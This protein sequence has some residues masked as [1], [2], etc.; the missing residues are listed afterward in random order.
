MTLPDIPDGAVDAAV[1]AW[2]YDHRIHPDQ[3]RAEARE[4]LSAVWPHLY[5]AALRHAADEIDKPITRL[6]RHPGRAARWVSPGE[7]LR[8]LADEAVPE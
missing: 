6:D 1:L 5:A 8:R 7:A 4:G 2:F 3:M